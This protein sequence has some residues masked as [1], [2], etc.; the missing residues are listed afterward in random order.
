MAD[1]LW[2]GPMLPEC[3][4]PVPDTEELARRETASWEELVEV[5]IVSR[6]ELKRCREV[7]EALVDMGGEGVLRALFRLNVTQF[8][9]NPFEADGGHDGAKVEASAD[10]KN[11]VLDY[12]DQTEVLKRAGVPDKACSFL[13]LTAL[14]FMCG[15]LRIGANRGGWRDPRTDPGAKVKTPFQKIRVDGHLGPLAGIIERMGSE[16]TDGDDDFFFVTSKKGRVAHW[17]HSVDRSFLLMWAR[18]LK[19]ASEV[20]VRQKRTREPAAIYPE[21]AGMF[22]SARMVCSLSMREDEQEQVRTLLNTFSSKRFKLVRVGRSVE[23]IDVSDVIEGQTVLAQFETALAKFISTI[24][25]REEEAQKEKEARKAGKKAERRVKPFKSAPRLR[26]DWTF[27][28]QPY[29]DLDSPPPGAETVLTPELL[30]DNEAKV[31][32]L[33]FNPGD[34]LEIP[35]PGIGRALEWW[36]YETEH[37]NRTPWG[38]LLTEIGYGYPVLSAPALP[39]RDILPRR[40]LSRGMD[41]AEGDELGKIKGGG[42]IGFML[43]NESTKAELPERAKSAARPPPLAGGAG[44]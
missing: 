14:G 19:K 34:L 20:K 16:G 8:V 29:F 42:V 36:H 35:T 5:A 18:T 2:G 41:F 28:L 12:F 11:G 24:D 6:P 44:N 13:N 21:P 26:D 7:A 23:G 43:E 39:L 30:E 4:E 9:Y 22:I 27:V 15:L 25:A 10:I 33:T 40:Y 38:Q 17:V 3:V 1:E 37:A 32:A 31:G